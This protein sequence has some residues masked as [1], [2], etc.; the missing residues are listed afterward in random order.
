M[1]LASFNKFMST[2]KSFDFWMSK[3]A[4]DVFTLVV[5][6][7]GMDWIPNHITIGLFE[8]FETS[9]QLLTKNLQDIVI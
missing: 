1:R 2:T 6:F 4:H 5:N 3:R 7:L 9:C 8:A